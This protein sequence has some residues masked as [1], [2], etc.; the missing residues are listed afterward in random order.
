MLNSSS[1]KNMGFAIEIL[2]L[3][4]NIWQIK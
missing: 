4:A 1:Q 2:G 3:S